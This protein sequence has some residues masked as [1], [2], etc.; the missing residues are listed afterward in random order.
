M[1]TS[2]KSKTALI[3]LAAFV[4]ASP[5]SASEITL[6][7]KDQ[8]IVFSGSFAGFEKGAYVIETNGQQLRVPAILATCKGEACLEAISAN[9]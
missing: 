2:F 6:T 9:S 3:V 8:N 1:F 7:L 4:A 5:A